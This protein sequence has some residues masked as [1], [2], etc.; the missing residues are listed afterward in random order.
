MFKKNTLIVMLILL[1]CIASAN[2][3]AGGD[4]RNGTGG[5]Q[6]LLLP[7][8]ARGLALNG[9]NV[10]GLEGIEALFYN[11]AGLGVTKKN[12]EALFSHQSYI[13]D[14]GI[15][16][17]AVSMN[18]EGFGSLAFSVKTIN[19][20]DIPVT[21]VENPAGTGSNFSPTFFTTGITYSNALTDRIR[22]GVTVNLISEKI[23]TTSASG[24][25]LNAG[26]QYNG[27]VG[28][29]GLKLGVVLKNIGPQMKF[30]G[31]DLLRYA[32]DGSA[33]RGQQFYKID[34]A[35]FELP[36]QLELGL[37]YEKNIAE[38]FK[39]LISTSFTNNNFSN[40]EYKLGAE[41]SYNNT[42]FLRGGYVYTKE[43][44]DNIDQQIF[45]PTFGGGINISGSL[46]IAVDYAYKQV[47]YFDGN[48][49]FSVRLGF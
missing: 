8:G 23:V 13:A 9:A 43:G 47:K 5:A 24:V 4:R 10:A 21:T 1:M 2:I 26:V 32:T 30:D 33:L 14:I 40:D 25:A 31:P 39:G 6:E 29:E 49:I 35:S 20:G 38:D 36:S 44:A 16:Y 41:V 27:I 15:S 48:H 22:V 28:L 7:V 46:D 17:A 45:G 37:A 3:Y 34:G 19:F 42:F 11:P 12:A 18:F